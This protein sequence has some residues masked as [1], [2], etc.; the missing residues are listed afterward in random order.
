[1]RSIFDFTL[2]PGMPNLLTLLI[3]LLIVCCS[4]QKTTSLEEN[5]P[6][7]QNW[8]HFCTT[9]L[10]NTTTYYYLLYK[11]KKVVSSNIIKRGKPKLVQ[12]TTHPGRMNN[13]HPGTLGRVWLPD[14][15]PYPIFSWA[16]TMSAY[17]YAQIR[18]LFPPAPDERRR[19][20]V[21]APNTI[22]CLSMTSLSTHP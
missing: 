16:R 14:R 2:E 13:G 7:F 15:F 8:R 19:Q 17:A 12:K 6:V 22:Q 21:F 1:M 11:N 4:W 5:A 20:P 9:L 10:N 18:P 3:F